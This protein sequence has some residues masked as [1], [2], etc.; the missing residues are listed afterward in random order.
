MV[1]EPDPEPD[2]SATPAN[3]ESVEG[4]FENPDE[5]LTPEEPVADESL[6]FEPIPDDNA[7]DNFINP[8]FSDPTY[9]STPADSFT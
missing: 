9:P 4:A 8:M 1:A 3:T 5:E 2:A 7:D 6:K